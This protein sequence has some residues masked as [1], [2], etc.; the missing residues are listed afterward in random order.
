MKKHTHIHNFHIQCISSCWVVFM[1]LEII[2]TQSLLYGRPW[3]CH[4]WLLGDLWCNCK[5]SVAEPNAFQKQTPTI[6]E[7]TVALQLLCVRSNRCAVHRLVYLTFPSIR[8]LQ[9]PALIVL[10]FACVTVVF[11]W[12]PGQ[13]SMLP[14][15]HCGAQCQKAQGWRSEA[16]V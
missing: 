10:S 1:Y 11:P 4:T 8:L 16:A 14:V 7:M 5:A 9:V 13:T 2:C 6:C 3:R 15:K 12:C